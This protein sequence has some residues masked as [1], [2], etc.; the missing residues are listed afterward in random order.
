[1]NNQIDIHL[2]VPPHA[3]GYTL[4]SSA[5]GTLTK[6][7]HKGSIKVSPDVKKIQVYCVLSPKW[8]CYKWIF[9]KLGKISKYVNFKQYFPNHLCQR[10]NF[11][12]LEWYS[13]INNNGNRAYLK[14][15]G[16]CWISVTGN[17][18]SKIH[19]FLNKKVLKPKNN[20]NNK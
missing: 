18:W 10:R 5:Y 1:M 8:N 6:I 19:T 9:F 12:K 15:S 13:E 14:T 16:M 17:L 7:G 20:N 3:V 11:K 4:L 2:I